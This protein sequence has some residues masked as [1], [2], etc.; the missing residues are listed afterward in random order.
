[1][2]E[3]RKVS[4]AHMRATKKWEDANYDKVLLR[5]PKGTNDRIIATGES[6]NGFIKQATLDRLD[7]IERNKEG[8]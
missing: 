7:A 3:K 5:L 1:M 4:Q 8:H 6:L 2:S